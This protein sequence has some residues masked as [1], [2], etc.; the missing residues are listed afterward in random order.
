MNAGSKVN[1]GPNM[2]TD[3]NVVSYVFSISVYVLYYTHTYVQMSSFNCAVRK[4]NMQYHVPPTRF[5][6]LDRSPYLAA[7]GGYT[8][9]QLNMRR[10]AEVLKYD[11][12]QKGNRI[13]SQTRAQRFS[14]VVRGFSQNQRARDIQTACETLPTLSTRSGV[15]G[16]PI[17]LQ[18]D[19]SV[20]LYNY[21]SNIRS[22]SNLPNTENLPWRLFLNDSQTEYVS[23][24]SYAFGALEILDAIPNTV[25]TYRLSIPYTSVATASVSGTA[26]LNV[27][28]GGSSVLSSGGPISVSFDSNTIVFPAITV[29]TTAGY[30]FEL[31][32]TIETG[33]ASAI[34]LTYD[35]VL[36]S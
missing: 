15:P 30:F 14:Q 36:L 34:S 13:N 5:S 11:G 16:P 31:E 6:V 20:P 33:D 23:G 24:T 12:S 9:D 32:L 8:Q 4:L 25:T 2:N 28:F 7:N 17:V 19:K 27:T 22:Y 21:A 3:S 10:K 18:L 26:Q 35:G 1:T 29:A